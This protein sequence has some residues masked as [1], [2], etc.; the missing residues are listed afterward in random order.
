MV[1]FFYVYFFLPKAKLI[2]GLCTHAK[3]PLEQIL[4]ESFTK[5]QL[6]F[7]KPTIQQTSKQEKLCWS[8][9]LSGL[10]SCSVCKMIITCL[11]THAWGR[12]SSD[13]AVNM[14]MC[15]PQY[16]ICCYFKKLKQSFVY[17]S[18]KEFNKYKYWLLICS[19]QVT[20]T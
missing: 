15:I 17:F 4:L 13:W 8:Q 16:P 12:T 5:L 1:L 2:I 9:T 18:L 3:Q 11:H 20:S 14:Y 10:F 19:Q 6:H 7:N